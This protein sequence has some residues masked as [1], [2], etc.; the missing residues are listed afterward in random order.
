M[1]RLL[2]LSNEEKMQDKGKIK[3]CSVP[4]RMDKHRLGYTKCW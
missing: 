4:S 2:R 1:K 3:Y